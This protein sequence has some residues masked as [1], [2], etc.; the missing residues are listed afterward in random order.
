MGWD[1]ATWVACVASTQM[2]GKV[3]SHLQMAG[4]WIYDCFVFALVVKLHRSP[5]TV[6][7]NLLKMC[8]MQFIVQS[9]S[10]LRS[11]NQDGEMK[12]E[13]VTSS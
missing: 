5:S 7:I 13:G 12:N 1:G 8:I 4:Q 3:L 11:R 6:S 2:Y 10:A 9:I